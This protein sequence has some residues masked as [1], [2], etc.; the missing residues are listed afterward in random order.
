MQTTRKRQQGRSLRALITALVLALLAALLLAGTALAAGH[1]GLGKSARPGKP[2]AKAPKGAIATTTPSFTWSKVA[3]AAKYEL[4]VYEGSTLLLKKT[5]IS[6]PPWNSRTALPTNVDLTWKVRASN[7]RGAGAWSKSLKFKIVPASPAKA[8]TAFSFQGLTPAV[9]GVINETLHTIVLTVPSGTN[10]TNLV[11]TFTTTGATVAVAGAPQASGVTAN[12]FTSPVTY[13]VTAADG[14]TQ[15]YVVTV[16]VVASSAKAIT[17]FSFQGLS[18]TVTGVITEA[19]HAV[20]LSVP[21]GTDLTNLVPTITITGASV[22]PASGVANNFAGPVTYTVTAAD[23]ST[24]AYM[25]TVAARADVLADV[26]ITSFAFSP[27]TL[28]VKPG[29]TVVWTNNDPYS[30]TVTAVD[31]LNLN[32]TPTGLFNSGYIA[33]GLT[34]RYTFTTPGTYYYECQIHS[35]RAA[36]HA[37]VNVQ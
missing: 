12:N 33:G 8:I 7:A 18:P 14:T 6:K 19:A 34:F 28:T 20:T 13:T 21:S 25:V 3:G 23:A 36:M 22:S 29:T 26:Q 27:K 31:S 17:A 35:E 37:Q 5:R 15:D 1:E 2:T 16:T 9:T 24:Q 30:H 10:L 11:A 4:R 32:A